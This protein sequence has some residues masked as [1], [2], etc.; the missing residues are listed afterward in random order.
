[1]YANVLSYFLTL[2]AAAQRAEMETKM[3]DMVNMM[4]RQEADVKKEYIDSKREENA[5]HRQ[6]LRQKVRTPQSS[7]NPWQGVQSNCL[8]AS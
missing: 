3:T 4:M 2:Q 6:K 8:F 5:L 1:M 7:T